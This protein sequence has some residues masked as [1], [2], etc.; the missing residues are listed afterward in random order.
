MGAAA[1]TEAVETTSPYHAARGAWNERYLNLLHARRNW[2]LIALVAVASNLVVAL[3]LVWQ[4]AQSKV[5]PYVVR[6]DEVGQSLVLGPA[7][8][9]TVTD[10][11][12]I[13]YQLQSYVRDLRQVTADGSAQKNLLERVYGQTAGAAIETLH[14]HFRT[15]SPFETARQFTVM[16]SVRSTLQLGDRTWQVEWTETRRTLEGTVSSEETWVG[17]FEVVVE[18]PTLAQEVVT[19]PLGF[20]VTRIS[21]SRKF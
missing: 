13:G 16:P 21:W 6:V 2:Q 5:V 8:A 11:K 18:P 9:S 1:A 15:T 12:I 7:T 14:E 4:S 3:G 19:N 20:K 17:Q 10:P